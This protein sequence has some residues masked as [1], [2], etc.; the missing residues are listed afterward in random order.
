[1]TIQR[2]SGDTLVG[3]STDSK[4]VNVLDGAR[5]F[6]LDS[7]KIYILISGE[8]IEFTGGGGGLP[9]LPFEFCVEAGVSSTHDID[10]YCTNGY[11]IV[12]AILESDGTLEGV[13]V[14]IDGT[15]ITGLDD[16]DVSTVAVFTATAYNLA[17]Q[18]ERVTIVTSGTDTGSPTVIRGK[19]IME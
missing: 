5:F 6:E 12:Q 11:T 2:Y 13:K 9:E 18:G 19:I 3:L 4:P 10:I 15:D 1:M 8:W 16:M 7:Q 14:K 17:A